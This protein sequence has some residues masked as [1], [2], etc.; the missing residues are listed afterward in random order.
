[1]LKSNVSKQF[2]IFGF[3]TEIIYLL[4]YFIEPLRKHLG[5]QSFTLHNSYLF[6]L[7]VGLLIS[8][9]IVYI[10]NYR[11]ITEKNVNLKTI[12]IFFI[13]FNLT[14][15]FIWPIGSSDIFGYI[16]QSRIISEYHANPYLTPYD[17]FPGD[18]FY[19]LIKNQW[20]T[21]TTPYGPIWV[22]IGSILS[23]IG[24]NN[25][26]FTL[27][28]FKLFFILINFLNFYLIYKISNSVKAVFLYAWNPLILYEFALNGHNDVLIVFFILISLFFF[29]QQNK[30]KNYIL[31]WIFLIFSVLIKFYTIIF[32]PILFLFSLFNLKTKKEKLC[33][34]FMA[35]LTAIIMAVLFF[36]PFGV[37]LKVFSGIQ[38]QL[39]RTD[40]IL[41]SMIILI[42][43]FLFYLLHINNYFNLANI[44]GKI[45][46]LI[47]YCATAI[48][49]FFN[50]RGLTKNDILKYLLFIYFILIATALGW[51]MP[52]YLVLLIV[53]LIL[54]FKN[55]ISILYLKNNAILYFITLY[56]ILY[57]IFLR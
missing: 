36:L 15:L 10:L 52:W 24:K 33:F 9:L 31:S 48:K 50:R 42:F 22:I 34:S 18:I 23:F 53:L 21:N 27:L 20:S 47:S 2:L 7:V 45:I 55:F 30:I 29:L 44:I 51:L 25:L 32:L 6:L 1:M 37:D 14:L 3:L 57:Y 38:A 46:F 40:M 26:V 56:G 8:A 16:Y 17:A 4:F 28:L 54:N 39:L 11:R 12:I 5:D 43:S 13:L 19:H 41:S 35:V 49:I